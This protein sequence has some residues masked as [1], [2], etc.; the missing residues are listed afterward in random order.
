LV[1]LVVVVVVV[2]VSAGS[3]GSPR[4]QPG[5][6]RGALKTARGA[7]TTTSTTTTPVI[8][9]Q[10]PPAPVQLHDDLADQAAVNSQNT[11]P[12]PHR[13]VVVPT[14]GVYELGPITPAKSTTTVPH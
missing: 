10:T 1:V 14:T 8:G 13:I 6:T 4:K 7:A 11:V 3:S 12:L 9:M 2:V 5:P